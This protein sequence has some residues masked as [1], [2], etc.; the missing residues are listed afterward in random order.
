MSQ[1]GIGR[2]QEVGHNPNIRKGSEIAR[3]VT[4]EER[5]QERTKMGK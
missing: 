1:E 3:S 5:D 4:G 2:D